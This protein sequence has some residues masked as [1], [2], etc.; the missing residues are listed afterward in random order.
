MSYGA[1]F[2]LTPVP[3]YYARHINVVLPVGFILRRMNEL[4]EFKLFDIFGLKYRMS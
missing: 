1:D 4:R 2:G 3:V